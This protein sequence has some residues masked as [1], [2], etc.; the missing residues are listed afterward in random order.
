MVLYIGLTRQTQEVATFAATNLKREASMELRKT[1]MVLTAVCFLAGAVSLAQE[2]EPAKPAAAVENAGDVKVVKT[3]LCQAVKDRDP[4]DEVEAAKVGD[5]VVGW[6]Q[7]SAAEDTTITHRWLREGETI[8]DVSLNIKKSPS[9]RAWSRKTIGIPGKWTWQILD[10]D[11][12]ILKE[13]SF[14]AGS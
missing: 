9:Y 14:T 2:P 5:V 13:V 3:V 1:L 10:A 11:G 8:S 7:I 6:T 12:N 4:Q